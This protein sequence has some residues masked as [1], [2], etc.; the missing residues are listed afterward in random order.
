MPDI[1]Y[2]TYSAINKEKWDACINSAPNGNIYAS[3]TYL[4]M[5]S[6]QWHALVMGDYAT[7]MPLTCN[8]KY[9]IHYLY[10]PAFAAALGI[11]GNHTDEAM[12]TAFLN[13]I[14]KKF[15]YCDIYLNRG[16]LFAIPGHLLY[17]RMNYILPLEQPYQALF[18]NFRE[19]TRRNIRKCMQ[20]H[21]EVI[22]DFDAKQVIRIAI[23]QQLTG[24]HPT[25][26][27]YRQFEKLYQVLHDR[28]KAI[29]YGIVNSRK[30][31]LASCIFFF[32][33]QR[34][35]YI[36]VGNHPDG[37]TVGASHML[38]N[39]FIEDHAEQKLIL[40]FEGSDI[41]NLA[42]FY[43]SFGGIPEPYPGYRFNRLPFW[44]KWF[45]Q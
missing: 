36:L 41:P 30:E 32:S 8:R 7:V 24:N 35:Y 28:K 44:A 9:G 38:I 42:F 39:A 14:P 10:Q 16:N 5:M 26:D 29:T 19:S 11:F 43:S 1:R 3:S 23:D 40:D 45:K 31:L 2:L 17:Q 12:V 27:A 37:K 4:D 34:A 33:H 25:T 6:G 21:H 20:L 22:R 15:R 13:A 18:K